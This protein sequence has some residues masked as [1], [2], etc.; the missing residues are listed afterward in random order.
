MARKYLQ[1]VVNEALEFH[2]GS[3]KQPES[4]PSVSQCGCPEGFKWCAG[5][6]YKLQEA[7]MTHDQ[8]EASCVQTNSHLAVPRS[9][10]ENLCVAV[11]ASE[12]NKWLGINDRYSEGLFVDWEGRPLTGEHFRAWAGGQPDDASDEEDC[13]E[14]L[15]SKSS[16]HLIYGKWNDRKCTDNNPSVCQLA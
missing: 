9:R 3:L 10:E 11:M 13:V 12:E 6:C 2:C 7:F 4:K 16:E 1:E 14:I 5:H 8:A 15:G